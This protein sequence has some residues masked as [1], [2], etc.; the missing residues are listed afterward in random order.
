MLTW[1]EAAFSEP[2]GES[3]ALAHYQIIRRSGA[4]VPFEPNK[5]AQAMMKAFMAVHGVY[6]FARSICSGWL[7]GFWR[8][9][10]PSKVGAWSGAR[11]A[12]LDRPI[13]VVPLHDQSRMQGFFGSSKP[14]MRNAP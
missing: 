5:I 6:A 7:H 1:K 9:L 14:D 8:A 3:P 11:T 4:V 2:A 13:R 12:S 10:K